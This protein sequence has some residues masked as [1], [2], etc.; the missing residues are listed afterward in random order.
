MW[1]PKV[2]EKKHFCHKCKNELVFEVKMGRRDQCPHCG[3]DEPAPRPSGGGEP[4]YAT[5]YRKS[6]LGLGALVEGRIFEAE[7]RFDHA[8]RLAEDQAGRSSSAASQTPD[9]PSTRMVSRPSSAHTDIS[10]SS[11]S[12]TNFTTSSGCARPMIG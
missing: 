9:R 2:E 7:Q 1:I 4:A 3:A 11:S 8:L 6:M 5:V 12:R 10:E